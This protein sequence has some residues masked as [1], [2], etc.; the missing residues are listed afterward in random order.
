[1][2][3]EGQDDRCHPVLGGGDSWGGAKGRYTSRVRQ[4]ICCDRG[5]RRFWDEQ[6]PCAACLSNSCFRCEPIA[7]G[8]IAH[9]IKKML[10]ENSSTGGSGGGP[11]HK[12]KKVEKTPPPYTREEC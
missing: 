11:T 4:T 1:M 2:K 6:R 10:P 8:K 5:C 7:E 12:R 9:K 3:K